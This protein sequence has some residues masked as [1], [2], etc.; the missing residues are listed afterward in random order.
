MTF[1]PKTPENMERTINYLEAKIKILENNHNNGEKDE[2]LFQIELFHLNET[3]QYDKLGGMLGDEALEGIQLLSVETR[4][5]IT[6]IN[7][8]SKAPPKYKSDCMIKMNKTEYIYYISIKSKNHANPAILNH[9]PRTA[10]VFQP[11]GI[12]NKYVDALDI[13]LKEYIDKRTD[14]LIGE[15]ISITKLECLKDEPLIYSEFVNVLSYFVFEGSG[16]GDSMCKPNSV[17][18]YENGKISFIKCR[19]IEEKK[20]YIESIY[21]EIVLSLRDKGMPKQIC[22]YCTPWVF[23]DYNSDG[24]IKYKGSLHIRIN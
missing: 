11:D 2:V 20:E 3:G 17:V 5:I 1:D 18:Y 12:L 15:D 24:T 23:N 7:T 10:K 19:N 21:N 4:D 13:I 14:K 6:D 16:K 8:I 9:T 22:E